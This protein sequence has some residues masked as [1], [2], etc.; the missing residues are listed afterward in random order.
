M[1]YEIGGLLEGIW[2]P[3]RLLTSHV[4]LGG[5]GL[6]FSAILTWLL[7]PRLAR[8]LPRD[9][10]R[11]H[12]V[13]AVNSIGK[14]VGAGL[15]FVSIFLVSALI[16]VPTRLPLLEVLGCILVAM[17]VGFLDDRLGGLS[18]YTLGLLDLLVSLGAAAALSQLKPMEIWIPL[19]AASIHL[20]PGLF[21][22]LA[23]I[24]IWMSINSTNCTDGVD[25]LSGSLATLSLFYLGVVLYVVLGNV[26]VSN[27]LLVPHYAEGAI[28]ALL[29]FLMIGCLAGYLWYNSSPSS[30]LMGDAGSRPLGLLIG[31][32]VVATGNPILLL[33][34][35]P[36]L[37]ANGGTGL[38]KVALL[39]F[40]RIGILRNIRFPLH[41][42]VRSVHGWSD[43]Q[44]LSR[45]ML[46]QALATPLLLLLLLK[47]R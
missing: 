30:I 38:V 14:P 21:V 8:R 9:G 35:S 19:M 3:A 44:V 39:R 6:A 23:T 24:V 42:H 45:F 18:E 32:L 26:N 2:G 16:F 47:L 28:W 10:G 12:S 15:V 29:A 27:Y 11:L 7:L 13:G 4:W 46:I 22:F 40:F 20:S 36:V 5:V 43:T 31:I 1:L 33:V 37:L 25:G 34:V 41:D 17:G